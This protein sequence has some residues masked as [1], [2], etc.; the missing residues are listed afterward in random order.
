MAPHLSILLNDLYEGL[1]FIAYRS[2]RAQP[3][4]ADF[5]Y[6]FV[7]PPSRFADH[8]KAAEI[9][10]AMGRSGRGNPALLLD[11]DGWADVDV[12]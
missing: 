9:W 11:A 7:G 5:R 4:F 12:D 2:L 6:N 3:G 1:R 10:R 8:V